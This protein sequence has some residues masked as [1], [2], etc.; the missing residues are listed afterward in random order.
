M[1]IKLDRKWWDIYFKKL[2]IL[3]SFTFE[4]HPGEGAQE[5]EV[6]KSSDDTANYSL[7]RLPYSAN[8]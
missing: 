8:E 3:L 1:N 4:E 5:K 6:K 2:K 7:I